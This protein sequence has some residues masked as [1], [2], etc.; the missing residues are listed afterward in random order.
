MEKPG[1]S[2]QV[3]KW[4]ALLISDYEVLGSNCDGGKIQLMTK[5]W[6]LTA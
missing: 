4:L 2:G 6:H 5:L 1:P 3:A